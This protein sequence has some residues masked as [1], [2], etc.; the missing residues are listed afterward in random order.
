M[1]ECSSRVHG[2][3]F[4]AKHLEAARRRGEIEPRFRVYS[5]PEEAIRNRT[6]ERGGCLVWTGA[7]NSEGYGVIRFKGKMIKAHRASWELTNGP[8]PP[9]MHI[10]HKCWNRA[11]VNVGHLRIATPS[12]N[13]SYTRGARPDSQT[14]VRNVTLIKGKYVVRV[15]RG[16]K[17][18]HIGTFRDLEEAAKA[19]ES[20]RLRI[21]GEFAGMA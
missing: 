20:A 9:G 3:G 14:G 12:Q 16:G 19:A 13:S 5:T 18:Y 17:T 2:K 1:P 7:L 21:H 10:D 11:C 4:C 6:E 15:S 8:I